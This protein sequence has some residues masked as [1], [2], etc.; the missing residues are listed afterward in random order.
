MSPLEVIALGCAGPTAV[1]GVLG[2]LRIRVGETVVVQGAGPVGLA[3]A[4]LAKL[5]VRT[6]VVVG[7][8][9]TRL[10]AAVAMGAADHVVDIEVEPDTQPAGK[11][12]RNARRRRR[13]CR[14]GGDRGSRR[15]RQGID[16]CRRWPVPRAR[17]VHRSRPVPL[18]PH[19]V[20]RSSSRC[21]VV[22]IHRVRTTSHTW[23][24]CPR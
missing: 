8:P 14:G 3:S 11:R 21:W 20:T 16:L 6:V 2:L 1:H 7:A 23:I 12:R 17:A 24:S 18:N 10:D 13:R 15:R 22:G 9:A 4:M 5:A 19:F